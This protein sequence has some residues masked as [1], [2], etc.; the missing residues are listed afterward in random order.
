MDYIA[1]HGILGMKWG[2]RRYQNEDG[3]LTEKGKARYA[4]EA[5]ENNWQI[6]QD[7]VARSTSRKSKGE[8]HAADPDKWVKEDITNTKGVTDATRQLATDLRTTNNYIN[9]Q[10]TTKRERMDLSDMTDQELRTKINR[11]LLERQYNDVFNPA[12][13]SKGR[14]YA[15]RILNATVLGLSITSSSLGIALAIKQLKG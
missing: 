8:A 5:K 2:V 1:H 15:D 9:S 3:T 13:V 14:V 11:E 6:G 10:R 4:Q 7:G 12:E